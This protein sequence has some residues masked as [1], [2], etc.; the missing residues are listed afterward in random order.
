M[1]SITFDTHQFIKRLK[2]KG[3]PEA[4]AEEIVLVVR[5][6]YREAMADTVDKSELKQL[7]TKEDIFLLKEHM[8]KEISPLKTHIAVLM[9]MQGLVVLTLV[10]PAL[11]GLL[12]L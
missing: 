1:S 7:A 3:M 9:W 5:D 11:K 4:Q 8:H 2:D 6:S 12:G 10:I